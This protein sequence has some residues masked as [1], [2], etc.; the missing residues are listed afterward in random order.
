MTSSDRQVQLGLS[1]SRAIIAPEGWAPVC[2]PLPS[3]PTVTLSDGKRSLRD[4]CVTVGNRV[5]ALWQRFGYL[6][7]NGTVVGFEI[8]V[9]DPRYSVGWVRV[10]IDYDYPDRHREG[11]DG[12]VRWDYDRTCLCSGRW[13]DMSQEESIGRRRH[14][15]A[16]RFAAVGHEGEPEEA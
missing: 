15:I 7:G 4:G 11:D 10:V 6:L 9:S 1:E 5:M 8:N 2:G 13:P 3:V 16:Q 14:H 12:Y